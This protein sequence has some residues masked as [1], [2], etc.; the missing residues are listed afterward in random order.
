MSEIKKVENAKV[1]ITSVVDGEKWAEAYN[2]AFNKL[3]AKTSIDGFRKGKAPKNILKKVINPQSVCYEAV[4]EIAQSV[5]E[6]AIK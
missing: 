3:A 2:K 5:L 4:D 6:E 1:E